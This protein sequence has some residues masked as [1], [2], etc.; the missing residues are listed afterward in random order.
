MGFEIQQEA[1][2]IMMVM[3]ECFFKQISLALAI[4]PGNRLNRAGNASEN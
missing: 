1:E 4:P 3:I 2:R